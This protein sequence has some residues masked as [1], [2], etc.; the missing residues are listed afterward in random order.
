MDTSL[1]AMTPGK[2]LVMPWN[3]MIGEPQGP[4]DRAEMR[5]KLWFP[6]SD[7]SYGLGNP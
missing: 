3:E 6:W 1:L 7:G 5:V 4:A 2:V